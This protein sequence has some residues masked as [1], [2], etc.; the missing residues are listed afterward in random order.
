MSDK[1]TLTSRREF[2]FFYDI[3]MGNPNGDPDENRPRVLPDKTHYVTD[4]RLKRFARD[5]LKSQ[6]EEILVDTIEGKTTNLT[7]RVAAYLAAQKLKQCEG[8]ELVNILLNA[9][10]DARLFGSS[11][12]FKKQDKW[13][14]T[15]E[16]KTLTGAVQIAHGEVKHK[17]QEV[18]INGT[19]VFGSEEGKTQGTFTTYYALRYALIGFNGVANQHSAKVSRMTDDD[20]NTLL[21]AMWYGVRSAGNTRTKRGQVP[22]LLVSVVYKPQE[23]FQF[24]NLCDYVK[25]VP[26]NGKKPEEWSLPEDYTI[27][28]TKLAERLREQAPRIERVE[29][30]ASPDVHLSPTLAEFGLSSV[31]VRD[32][33]LD[34]PSAR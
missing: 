16:P 23:E 33:E 31:T 11:F 15:A 14:P 1:P 29:Y 20:Y 28:L 10:I 32:M 18:D 5:Y 4:V 30:C 9:F 12:A 17:A 24:G 2:V 3:K 19:S 27:D 34:K 26:T 22:R 21:K 8:A 6:G 13:E 25:L 7:G